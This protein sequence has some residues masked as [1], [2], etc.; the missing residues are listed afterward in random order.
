MDFIMLFPHMNR[1][2]LHSHSPH[3]ISILLPDTDRS[4]P[5]LQQNQTKELKL[6]TQS[7]RN[8]REI[9]VELFKTC[10]R[11]QN[12]VEINNMESTF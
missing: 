7:H 1:I 4:R 12:N 2:I 10:E 5:L 11:S 6:K 9:N 8:T 3:S